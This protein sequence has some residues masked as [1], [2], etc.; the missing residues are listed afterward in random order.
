MRIQEHVKISAVAAAITFP[1]LKKDIW[2]PLAASILIDVD[3]YLWYAITH[4]TLSL[5]AAVSFFGQADPPQTASMKVFHHPLFLGTLLFLAVRFRSRLL[6]LILSGLLF[7]LGLDVIHI[8]QMSHLKKTLSEQA[9]YHCPECG[10]PDD[11]LQLHTVYFAKNLLDRYNPRH[12]VVLCA[13][14]HE[15]AHK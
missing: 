4:R 7:H 8:L 10:R 3:H 2:I 6:G 15:L 1:W 13:E 9:D 12:F 11:A 14:C 5:R